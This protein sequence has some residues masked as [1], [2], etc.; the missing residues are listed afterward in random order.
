LVSCYNCICK[1]QMDDQDLAGQEKIAARRILA[2]TEEELQRIVLDI[3]DGPVQ[4]LFAALSQVNLLQRQIR[5]VNQADPV[6]F[7]KGLARIAL[8]LEDSLT[9]IRTFLGTFRPPEFAKRDL[10]PVLEALI[11]QFET[12]TGNHVE[13]KVEGELPPVSLPVKIAL[14][15]I[16]QE[17]L[18]NSYR[19]AEVREQRVRLWCE[20]ETLC[21]E[22]SDRGVG[23]D[24]PPLDGPGATEREEH[25]G[26]R[27]MRDRV[28]LVGGSFELR[29]QPGQGT[30]ITVRV[31]SYE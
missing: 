30:R 22:V 18:S 3:H 15:R 20:G 25:I 23:F 11:I 4:K 13:F 21:L 12:N 6:L 29:S 5:Y 14:Y 8:L 1:K 31:P 2:V 24:P 10:L 7:T 19:H 17:A 27:G 16:V 26:L 9:E 28:A